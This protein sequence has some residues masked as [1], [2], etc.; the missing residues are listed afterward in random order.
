[1]STLAQAV[2]RVRLLRILRDEQKG[3]L[4]ATRDAFEE[5]IAAETDMVNA[6]TLDLATAENEVKALA[7]AAYNADP[8]SKQLS[9]G[10][11]IRVTTKYT[12]T[13]YGKA[14]EWAQETGLALL[15]A[16]LDETTLFK[17]AKATPLPF[18]ASS[19]TVSVTLAKELPELVS[20]SSEAPF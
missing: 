5:S 7:L 10:V 11:S 8:S 20:T 9:P 14:T 4:D 13:D 15:P 19:E 16:R 3:A 1:M 12:V 17:I 18:V 6:L 2:E